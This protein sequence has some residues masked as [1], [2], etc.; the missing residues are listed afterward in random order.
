M[1][2]WSVEFVMLG[3]YLS[4]LKL[5][6]DFSKE[7]V[8]FRGFQGSQI[9]NLLLRWEGIESMEAQDLEKCLR[10]C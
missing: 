1:R 6:F 7:V 10:V 5:G 4:M 9:Q 3:I 8:D 2:K